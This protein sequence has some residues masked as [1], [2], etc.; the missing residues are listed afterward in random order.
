[1]AEKIY[2]Y[3]PNSSPAVKKEMLDFIGVSSVEELYSFIPEKLLLKEKMDLPKPFLA[4][5]ELKKHVDGILAQ[6]KTCGE[7]R[8]FLGAGCYDHYVPA[9]CDEINGRSEFLTAYSGDTYAD[10]G[11]CQAFFEFTSMMGELLDM[12][13]VGFPTYDGGQAASTALRMAERITKRK[14]ALVPE[15]M[16][17]SLLKQ[18]RGYCKNME[19]I[20]VKSMENGQ[21]DLSDLKEKLSDKTACVFLQ[22]PS[23]LGFFEARAKE[24]GELAHSAGA[25]FIVYADPSSLGIAAPPADYGADIACGDIQPLGIHMSCGGGLGGYLA[26]KQEEKYVMNYPHHL[27]SLFENSKGQFGYARAL[28]E[29]T[30]YYQ[31]EKGV[32]FLGTCVGL[33]A[34]TAAVYLAVMGPA[35]MRELGENILYK[36]GYARKKLEAVPGLALPFKESGSF[37]EFV[38]NVDGTGKTVKEINRALLS[39]GIFGGYDLSSEFTQYGQSMLICVTEKTETDDIDALCEALCEIGKEG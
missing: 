7:Y 27:Y 31:R 1:M 13:V 36:S 28:P 5:Q 2:P 38:V 19:L 8:S 25:E 17:P 4:E 15:T 24:I 18:M 39:R 29:R 6:N 11:K 34:V 35:G 12:D 9:V 22:N 10:H 26:T 30:S 37:L 3:I 16:N 32:E 21:M 33:W 23:F 20:P 14:Q